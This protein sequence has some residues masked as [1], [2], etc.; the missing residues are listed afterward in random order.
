MSGK[1]I[2]ARD[3]IRAKQRAQTF[4]KSSAALPLVDYARDRGFRIRLLRHLGEPNLFAQVE[5]DTKIIS[6]TYC[7]FTGTPRPK[8]DLLF[9]LAH[10]VR[11]V[12][13]SH[14]R[15]FSSYYNFLSTPIE[16][17]LRSEKSPPPA[18]ACG[19][20]VGVRAER[21]CDKV[22]LEYVTKVY[23][24]TDGVSSYL[25]H[26][27]RAWDVA[28]YDQFRAVVTDNMRGA[29]SAF[30]NW[31]QKWVALQ[32][33]ARSWRISRKQRKA[34]V[35][36]SVDYRRRGLLVRINRLQREFIRV[37]ELCAEESVVRPAL[38]TEIMELRNLQARL[39]G[40]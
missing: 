17:S 19:L 21:D 35:R 37:M 30:R 26:R 6:I 36:K 1:N 7:D 16:K 10:E 40:S 13:H 23:G 14:K 8:E 9:L 33:D 20:L 38:E 11:H 24:H 34:G 18:S 27:Y 29:T 32:D 12:E 28:G 2:T 39:R 25:K 3:A 15:L 4:L 31:H 22:A 5:M